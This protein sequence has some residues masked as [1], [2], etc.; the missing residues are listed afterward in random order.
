MGARTLEPRGRRLAGGARLDRLDS[1][2]TGAGTDQQSTLRWVDDLVL[3]W[4]VSRGARCV[5]RYTNLWRISA[6]T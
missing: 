4:K 2:S 3:N 6:L 5:L 1:H